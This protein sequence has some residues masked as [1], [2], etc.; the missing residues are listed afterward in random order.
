MAKNHPR[1]SARQIIETLGLIPHPEGGHYLETWRGPPQAGS[2]RPVATAI[3]FLLAGA[4][5]SHWHRVDADEIWMFN[6]GTPVVLHLAETDAGP[7]VRHRLGPDITGGDQAQV[8]VPAGWGQSAHLAPAEGGA[9]DS[10]AA[11]S[12]AAGGWGLV[13][14]VVAPGF[15]FSGFTLAPPGFTIGGR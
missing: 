7:V 2:T 6:A 9:A 12:G 8:V 10:G 15:E 5:R 1:P 11:D 3:V 4:E 13:S 14:C